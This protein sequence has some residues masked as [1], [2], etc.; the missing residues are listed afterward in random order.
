MR[1]RSS[2][3]TCIACSTSRWSAPSKT[4]TRPGDIQANV[5]YTLARAR[6]ISASARGSTSARCR[7]GTIDVA[8]GPGVRLGAAVPAVRLT[9][10]VSGEVKVKLGPATI[11]TRAC[12][13]AAWR[14][15]LASSGTRRHAAGG[16]LDTG[17][18]V[19]HR[20]ALGRRARPRRD[21][22]PLIGFGVLVLHRVARERVERPHR[23]GCARMFADPTSRR[24]S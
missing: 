12:T 19:R 5:V 22:G 4:P 11:A 14:W 24:A 13:A 21:C 6:R 10:A 18:P 16:Q 2:R 9:I 3:S 17:R 7:S 8:V 1:R 15:K 23:G 20:S